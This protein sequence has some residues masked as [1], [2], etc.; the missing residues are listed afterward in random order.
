MADMNDLDIDSGHSRASERP[1]RDLPVLF[2][3]MDV[4][5]Q[6]PAAPPADSLAPSAVAPLP[7]SEPLTPVIERLPVTMPIAEPQAAQPSMAQPSMAQLSMAQSPVSVPEPVAVT[8][9]PPTDTICAAPSAS[10]ATA[11]KFSLD[12]PIEL[13]LSPRESAAES[14]P[15]TESNDSASLA[16]P[17]AAVEHPVTPRP[18]FETRRRLRMP[19]SEDW[20]AAHGRYIAVVFV[21]ALIGTVYLARLN[22]RPAT[23]PVAQTPK[24]DEKQNGAA[25]SPTPANAVNSSPLLSSDSK[26]P[27]K[28]V[29]TTS[30]VTAA[31][32]ELH[33]PAA[34]EVAGKTETGSKTADSLFVFPPA[35]P[36]EERVAARPESTPAVAN[37]QVNP[38]APA[39]PQFGAANSGGSSPTMHFAPP[40][41]PGIPSAPA[42]NYPTTAAPPVG[43]PTTTP[44]QH[45][46]PMTAAP[47]VNEAPIPAMPPRFAPGQ[48]P[49]YQPVYPTQPVYPAQPAYPTTSTFQP[50]AG[51]PPS[52]AWQPPAA[53]MPAAPMAAARG[54]WMP[55]SPG[56]WSPPPPAGGMPPQYQPPNN[57]ASGF[58]NERTG[59]GLY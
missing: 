20:F 38:P 9:L 11:T 35:K 14:S 2:H 13:Q 39:A 37:P 17:K 55:N 8:P 24:A 15:T 5:R 19:F 56:G 25:T 45:A 22:R 48:P 40:A 36:A 51:H 49:T 26:S 33:P 4:S 1:K 29:E 23:T 59:S 10:P 47:P 57:T 54:T 31:R 43:Y 18:P 30:A 46:Y 42:P 7:A 32:T 28:L 16:E 58:R 21:I 27:P 41:A 34:T 44:P 53:Q 52:P 3:L 6:R 12:R 50:Q